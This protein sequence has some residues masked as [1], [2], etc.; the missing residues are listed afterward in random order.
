MRLLL[1]LLPIALAGCATISEAPR[2]APDETPTW[3]FETSDIAA[4]PDYVFGTLPNGM[5]YA[6][7]QNSTPEGTALV[8]MNVASGSLSETDDERGYAHFLEHMAF[9]GSKRIPEG[10]MIKLLE[11]EGLAFGADT[12]ASTSFEQTQYKLDLPRNDPA[13]LGTALMLMRETASELT[14]AEDAVERERGVVLSERRDRN[15]YGLQ[16]TVDRFEFLTPGARYTQ[17]LPIGTIET[18]QAANAAG[19]RAFYA[20]EY[21]PA[22]T[23]IIIVG[24]FDAAIVKA[25]IEKHFGDWQPAPMPAEPATGPIDLDRVGETDIYIDPALSER[26]TASRHGPWI[27]EPDSIAVRRERLFRRIGYSIINRRLQR[28]GRKEDAAFRGA[29]FGT[30]ETFEIGRTTNLVVDA[31]DGEWQNGFLTAIEIWNRAMLGGFTESE[32]AEQVANIRTR[33]ENAVASAET[34]SHGQYLGAILALVDGDIVP[35]TPQDSLARFEAIVPDITPDSVHKAMKSHAVPLENP[36]I[37]FRGRK[38]PEGGTEALRATWDRAIIPPPIIATT[39]RTKPFAYDEFGTPAL[40]VSDTV[41]ERFGL[42]MLTFTNGLKLNL[43]PTDL[44]ADRIRFRL[45]VDGGQMLN[46]KTDPLATSLVS[47]LPVGGLGEHTQDELQSILAG[48]SVGFSIGAS[49][50]TFLLGGGT[51]KRDFELQ[52]Q[53]ITAAITDP[54]YRKQGE[55]QYRRNIANFFA[56]LNATPSSA[57]RNALGEIISE[58]DPRFSLQSPEEYRKLSFERLRSTITDRLANG[59]M[60]LTVVGDFEE[61]TVIALVAKTLGA[62]PSREMDFRPY[63]DRRDRSFTDDRSQ[64]TLRHTG[65][66]DQAL[67]YRIWPTRDDEDLNEVLELELLERVMR[68]QLT[69][70]LREKLGKAYSPGASSRSSGTYDD[71]GTFAISAAVDV[72]EV[73]ATREAIAATVEALRT[74]PVSQDTLDRARRPVL[75]NYDNALKTNSGWISVTDQAQSNPDRRER[76][77]GQRD[78]LTAITPEA[79]RITAERYLAFEDGLELLVLPEDE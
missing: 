16:E 65:E 56:R 18:L 13:L 62:L 33:G 68:L 69:D 61:E 60:E 24:D 21:V 71:Y 12:N 4:D 22:N 48:R 64:R 2:V 23:T 40:P 1:G 34:R 72:Q 27:D 75:E 44:Q 10:E 52:M 32:V 3:A 17:R 43:K 35:S 15:T 79:I 5:R 41:D 51:T 55:I 49:D 57:M 66:A 58:G 6:I 42:R 14:I 70:S 19:L 28:E 73:D 76:Y 45:H 7:R 78:L 37:R 39:I 47:S 54:G 77:L 30:G 38:V 25:E 63:D 20:R 9:N 53:L 46:T 31:G 50:D 67:L 8:R 29:G 11:R 74:E 36:L 59:A 26:V